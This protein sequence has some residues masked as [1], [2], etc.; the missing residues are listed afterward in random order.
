MAPEMAPLFARPTIEKCSE[1][2]LTKSN[3]VILVLS[4]IPVVNFFLWSAFRTS[5][6]VGSRFSRLSML[7]RASVIRRCLGGTELGPET[8]GS[9]SGLS[10][11]CFPPEAE[12][13]GGLKMNQL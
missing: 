3:M 9:G 13:A 12:L 7:S 2:Q 1:F 5:K 8:F 10:F 4:G 6:T 11:V